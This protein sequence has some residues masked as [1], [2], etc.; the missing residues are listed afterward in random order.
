MSLD[1]IITIAA[2]SG[3][4]VDVLYGLIGALANNC[5]SSTKM[6]QGLLHKVGEIVILFLGYLIQWVTTSGVD[7]GALG[8]IQADIPSYLIIASYIF[9]M[10]VGSILELCVKYNPDL[11]SSPIFKIFSNGKKD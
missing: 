5:F 10:E 8:Y 9:I 7:F 3:M 11:K 4:A 6:R 2:L 1:A